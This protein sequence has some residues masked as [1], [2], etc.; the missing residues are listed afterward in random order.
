MAKTTRA[1]LELPYLRLVPA[2]GNYPTGRGGF[3][4]KMK[5]TYTFEDPLGSM[6]LIEFE[7]TTLGYRP[8]DSNEVV[9]IVAGGQLDKKGVKEGWRIMAVGTRP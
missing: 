1:R 5:E 9:R 6:K 7:P 4:E 3:C 8:K 2:P